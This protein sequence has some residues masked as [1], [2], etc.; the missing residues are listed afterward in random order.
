MLD[1]L[2][3]SSSFLD[4]DES[5]SK[6]E[7]LVLDRPAR[8]RRKKSFL[9]LTAQQRF[10]LSLMIFFMVCVMGMFALVIS[11]SISLPF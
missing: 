4:E 3:N 8:R 7:D 1:D 10:I 9:G 6:E 2:R 11:G 5:A